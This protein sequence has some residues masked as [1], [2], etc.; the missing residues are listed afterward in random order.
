MGSLHGAVGLYFFDAQWR[1]YHSLRH[2]GIMRSASPYPCVLLGR[3]GPKCKKH[4]LKCAICAMMMQGLGWP[5]LSARA[6]G[7]R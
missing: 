4:L 3:E 5:E 1:A 7:R 2:L 6:T